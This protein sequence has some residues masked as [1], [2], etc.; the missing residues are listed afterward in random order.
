[1]MQGE[2]REHG[3]KQG[4]LVLIIAIERLFGDAGLQGNRIHTRSLKARV[5]KQALCCRMNRVAL[6][7]LTRGTGG[8]GHVSLLVSHHLGV[9]RRRLEEQLA[10]ATSAQSRAPMASHPKTLRMPCQSVKVF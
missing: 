2:L 8:F 7:L 6:G 1:M 10:T 4:F 9:E 3:H 5:Q